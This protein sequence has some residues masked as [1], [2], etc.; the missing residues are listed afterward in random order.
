MLTQPYK[1]PSAVVRFTGPRYREGPGLH[2]H[3]RRG[4]L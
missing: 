2:R 3:R 1:I 4:K